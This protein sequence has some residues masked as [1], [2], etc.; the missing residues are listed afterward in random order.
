MESKGRAMN[1]DA[2]FADNRLNFKN[3]TQRV[4]VESGRFVSLLYN[5]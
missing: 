3:K 4:E 1:R 5:L 2:A